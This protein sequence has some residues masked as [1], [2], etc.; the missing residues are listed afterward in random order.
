MP[1]AA[2]A[3]VATHFMPLIVFSAADSMSANDR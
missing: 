1:S 3:A 2:V